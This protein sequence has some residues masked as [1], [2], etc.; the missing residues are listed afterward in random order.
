MSATL[1]YRQVG[2]VTVVDIEGRITLGEGAVSLREAVKS[3]V[4]EGKRK[5]I[6]NLSDTVYVDSSGVGE[7]VSGF[8]QLNNQG[9]TLKLLA[10]SKRV[11]ELFQLINI[12]SVFE[13]FETEADAVSSFNK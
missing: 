5:I 10:L 2:D 6:L 8:T 12:Y 1:G 11:K 3:L 13:V 9:G 4:A 7:L